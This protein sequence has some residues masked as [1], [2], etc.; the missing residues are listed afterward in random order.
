MKKIIFILSAAACIY[1]TSCRNNP[2]SAAEAL[3]AAAKNP[4][5]NVSHKEYAVN[6]PAGWREIDTTIVGVIFHVIS[7]PEDSSDFRVNMAI[8]NSNMRGL[9]LEDFAKINW[10]NLQSSTP[11]FKELGQGDFETDAHVK[12]KWIQYSNTRD[13]YNFEHITYI[14]PIDGIAYILAGVCPLGSLDKYRKDFDAIAKSFH[15]K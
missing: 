13:G 14:I 3:E 7:A 11:A 12:A 2:K 8:L 6:V 1:A 10:S 9:S 4:N 15:L 5:I